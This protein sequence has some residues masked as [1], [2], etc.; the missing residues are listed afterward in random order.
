MTLKIGIAPNSWGVEDP[1]NPYNPPYEKVFDEAK[2]AGYKGLELGPYGYLPYDTKVLQEALNQR[3]LCIVAGTLYDD[4]VSTNNLDQLIKKTH[5]TCALM[6]KLPKADK[7]TGQGFETPYYVIIDQ[8]NNVRGKFAGQPDIAPRLELAKWKQMMKH[9]KEI[10]RITW[11]NYGIRSVVHPHAGGFIEF[12]D[13]TIQLLNDIPSEIA[14]LCLDTGHLY[15]AGLDPAD[16]LVKC[17]DRLDYIHFKDINKPVFENAVNNQQDFFD[18]CLD[19]VM[20]PI[21]KGVVDYKGVKDALEKIN[22]RGWIM[23]E[24]E[25][26]PRDVEGSLKDVKDSRAYLAK[27]G[28]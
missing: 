19:G 7:V 11:E 10:G 18:A 8:V 2:K 26:D 22:Y 25:R 27:I 28:Y 6:S 5:E 14:G 3:E 15:Y 16:W 23:L 21:G 13:E 24:Q 4:L 17:A 20:C 1:Q 9:I 12:G